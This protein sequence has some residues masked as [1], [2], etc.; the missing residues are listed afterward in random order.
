MEFLW[1]AYM[2]CSDHVTACT[3]TVGALQ[4]YTPKALQNCKIET[5]GKLISNS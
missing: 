4:N 2:E 5:A 3:D 1:S